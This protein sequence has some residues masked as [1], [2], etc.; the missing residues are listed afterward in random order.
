MDVFVHPATFREGFGLTLLEAMVA[1]IP[2]VA[3]DIWAINTLIRNR[4]NGY[5]VAPKNAKEIEKILEE[6]IHNPESA[7][8]IAANAYET[9]A[10]NY[11]VERMVKEME[12]VYREI[13]DKAKKC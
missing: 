1:K 12:T 5:L 11:S 9:A 3:S 8:A 6:I 10:R 2:V 7:G 13:V 4:V